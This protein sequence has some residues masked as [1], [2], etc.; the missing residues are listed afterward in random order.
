MPAKIQ[1]MPS[2]HILK[3]SSLHKLY[4][5]R[6]KPVA[7]F[8]IVAQILLN[9]NRMNIY[10]YSYITMPAQNQVMTSKITLSVYT[11]I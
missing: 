11:G 9:Q 7:F 5:G 4:S 6:E 3:V 1:V 8:S 2:K 10:I